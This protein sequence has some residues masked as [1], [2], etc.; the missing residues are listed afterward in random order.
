MHNMAFVLHKL[1]FFLLICLHGTYALYNL[2]GTY[3]LYN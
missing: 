3:A 1:A 2:H